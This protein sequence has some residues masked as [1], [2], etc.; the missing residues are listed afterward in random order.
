[1]MQLDAVTEDMH[2]NGS[3]YID[4]KNNYQSDK[5][6][7]FEF[8]FYLSDRFPADEKLIPIPSGSIP[9]FIKTQNPISLSPLYGKFRNSL[10]H[11]LVYTQFLSAFII[12]LKSNQQLSKNAMAAFFHNLSMQALSK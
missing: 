12:Y 1:M 7:N 11:E 4:Y 5:I 10:S 9:S 8:L 2:R 6:T 3:S